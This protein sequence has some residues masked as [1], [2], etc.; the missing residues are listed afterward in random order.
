MR[1]SRDRLW[2]LVDQANRLKSVKAHGSK[3]VAQVGQM[4]HDKQCPVSRVIELLYE[5]VKKRADGSEQALVAELEKLY[6]QV[7]P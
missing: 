7:N 5:E 6:D 1:P 2:G 4:L 3:V